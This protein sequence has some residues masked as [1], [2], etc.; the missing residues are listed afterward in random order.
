[1]T[2][3][4]NPNKLGFTGFPSNFF[5]NAAAVTAEHENT[6]G[7]PRQFHYPEKFDSPLYTTKEYLATNLS[8]FNSNVV[9]NSLKDPIIGRYQSLVY[10][11]PFSTQHYQKTM[12]NM[13]MLGL[14]FMVA[15]LMFL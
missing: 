13:H 15:S 10:D 7:L 3:L 1:M 4:Y 9:Q 12:T 5:S 14:G 2:T 8:P 11:K 6:A